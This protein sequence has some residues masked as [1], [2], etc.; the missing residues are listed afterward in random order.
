MSTE[1]NWPPRSAADF[2][3]LSNLPAYVFA[4]VNAEKMERI[5]AGEDV[6]DL[7][8]G[9]PDIGAPAHIVAEMVAH[10]SDHRHH[11]YS[12]SRGI[13]GLRDAMAEH[14]ARRYDVAL[15]S[16]TEVVVTIGAK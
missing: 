16:E 3:R 14:Y 12:A 1:Q 2:P 8:M 5:Q 11:R 15:D 6:I 4:Q 13:Y 7:G 9:N 10:A